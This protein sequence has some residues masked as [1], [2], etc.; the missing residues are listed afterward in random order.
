MMI[1]ETYRKQTEKLFSKS[2]RHLERC[3]P[4]IHACSRLVLLLPLLFYSCTHSFHSVIE[5][6]C[7]HYL[8][9]PSGT[10]QVWVWVLC[11]AFEPGVVQ[12]QA[13]PGAAPMELGNPKAM[14]LEALCLWMFI[15][16]AR[17]LEP[18]EYFEHYSE[19][20]WCRFGMCM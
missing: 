16:E 1:I 10:K 17:A 13:L 14:A 11:A 4:L 19:R 15:F 9:S 12:R 8:A 6:F 20:L 7:S 18:Q 3:R 5:P 2:K